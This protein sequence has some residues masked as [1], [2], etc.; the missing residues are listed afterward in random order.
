MSDVQGRPR[1]QAL[2]PAMLARVFHQPA[3]VYF[4]VVA[5]CLAMRE[6]GRRMSI[7]SSAVTRQIA[8][9]ED[10]L[11]LPLFNR[12]KG[13]LRLSSAGEILFRHTRR[14]QG[15][16]EA[17][18]AELDLLKGLKTGRVNIATVESIGVAILPRFIAAFRAS[19]PRLHLDITITSSQDVVARL[20]DERADIGFG[21]L[22]NPP[23]GISVAG[24]RRVPIGAVMLPGH[25][26]AIAPNVTL[27]TCLEHSIAIAKPEVSIRG[28]IEPFLRR[29]AFDLPPL[30]EVDSIRMLVELALVGGHVSIMTPVGAHNELAAGTLVFRALDEPGLPANQFSLLTRQDAML[31]YAVAVFYEQAHEFLNSIELPGE[32]RST[33]T[34]DLAH[35]G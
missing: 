4:N 21:F 20:L 15:S 17:A 27:A 12:Q 2:P 18:L 25:P 11:G 16:I 3:L 31:Q 14:L 10:A 9:L 22:V 35:P 13:R 1:R 23:R 6:A 28:V 34:P 5:E 30:V 29:T 26:L 32:V 19:Y 33:G 24:P 8:Q 7:S